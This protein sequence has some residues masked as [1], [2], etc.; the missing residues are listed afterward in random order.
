MTTEQENPSATGSAPAGPG[1]VAQNTGQPGTQSQPGVETL[2][3]TP[4]NMTRQPSQETTTTLVYL[5]KKT[6]EQTGTDV[7]AVKQKAGAGGAPQGDPPNVKELVM[8]NLQVDEYYEVC[9]KKAR[10]WMLLG[11]IF[12]C[13]GVFLI[14]AFILSFVITYQRELVTSN[15]FA[16]N[17]ITWHNVRI[18]IGVAFALTALVIFAARFEKRWKLN[19]STLK[20]L[21]ELKVKLTESTA[22]PASIRA[23]LEKV[24]ND[25]NQA[26][27]NQ[28]LFIGPR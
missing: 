1:A 12:L 3:P 14:V 10:S 6:Q 8:L 17:V 15:N 4:E 13:L 26:L 16:G 27:E 9:R 24:V 21:A 23:T 25:H 22:Q 20:K 19:Q 5:A 11:V 7:A 18:L 28:M 2:R